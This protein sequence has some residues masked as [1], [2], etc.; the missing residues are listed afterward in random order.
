MWT[1]RAANTGVSAIIDSRGRV[2]ARTGLFERDLIVYDVALRPPPRG[3]SFYTRHGD[4]FAGACWI[5]LLG[6]AVI[7]WRRVRTGDFGT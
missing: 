7:G 2:R 6:L 4:V 3:G 5:G 1:A